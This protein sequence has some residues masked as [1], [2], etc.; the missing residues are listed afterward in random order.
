MKFILGKKLNM[1]QIWKGEEVIPVTRIQAGPCVV[2]Q[3]KDKK[4][5]GYMGVQLGYGARKPKNIKK[6]QKGHF[7][8]LGSFMHLREFRLDT[9]SAV[10]PQIT[11]ER[12]DM[13]LADTFEVG[14]TIM[15]TGTSKGKGFQGGVKRHGFH[16]QNHTHGNKDQE[17]MPGSVGATGPQRVFKGTRM[18]GRMG[19]ARVTVKNL[20]I[21]EVD[22]ENNI[23]LVSG[24]VP[25]SING[26]IMIKGDGELKVAKPAAAKQEEPIAEAVVAP[27]EEIKNNEAIITENKAEEPAAAPVAEEVK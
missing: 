1:T 7:G 10:N 26:F 25:G 5:D 4:N 19:N 8:D 2:V 12:G 21:V 27:V 24:A 20:K 13:V 23:L 16:G 3:V 17:R 11:M 6:P 18:A 9:R 15:V 22:L 14:N